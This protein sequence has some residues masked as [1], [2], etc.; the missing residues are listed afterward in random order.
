[1]GKLTGTQVQELHRDHVL[2]SWGK[3]GQMAIPVAKAEGIYLYD[4]EGNKYADMSSLLVC[5]NLGHDNKEIV[6]ALKEQADWM[7]FMAPSY[8]TEAKSVLAKKLVDLAGPSFRRVFFTN[9]GAESNENAIKMARM[10]TGRT[11]IFS[12]Y[13]SYHGATLGASNASGDARRFAAELGGANGFVKFMNPHMYQDGYTRGVDDEVCTTNYLKALEQQIR[14]EGPNQIA[15]ILMES[16]V[17][18]NGVILPP[19]GYM[20]GVRA[21]CDKYGILLIMDEVMAGFYRTGTAFG[22]QHFDLVPDMI[23]FA[24]G[25]TNAYVPLGGVIVNEQISSYFEENVLQCGLTYSGHTLACAVGNACVDYYEAHNIGAHV[26]EMEA[27]LKDF[28]ETMVEKHVCVGE[29]R[30]IGLFSAFEMVKDKEN[31]VSLVDYN[32]PNTAMPAIMNQLKEKGFIA[33]NRDNYVSICPPLTI[34]KEELAEYLPIVDEVFTWV[35][36]TLI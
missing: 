9:S 23:T 4:Y 32:E 21:L 17:G 8:A 6:A 28:M 7:S 19:E 10:V 24:K 5:T 20:E 35:D 12:C 26:V 27:V 2:Q 11:K 31:R 33:F 14:Y 13:R 34:T 36:E 3:A 1:M 18:A 29:A 30:C 15:A 22:W 16:I 25:V